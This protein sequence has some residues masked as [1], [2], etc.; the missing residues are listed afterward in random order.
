M[1]IHPCAI[2]FWTIFGH[3]ITFI[4]NNLLWSVVMLFVF[5]LFLKFFRAFGPLIISF[6]PGVY[7]LGVGALF[8]GTAGLSA[9]VSPFLA[10]FGGLLWAAIPLSKNHMNPLI[11][12]PNA[13]IM[14]AVGIIAGLSSSIILSFLA[15]LIGVLISFSDIADYLIGILLIVILIY[16]MPIISPA[17]TLTC[18]AVNFA[19]SHF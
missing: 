12:I 3:V 10:I 18:E 1:A 5:S 11:M 6:I 7:G 2:I 17:I 15:I 14:F 16:V 4:A 8:I 19:A 9:T 13:V